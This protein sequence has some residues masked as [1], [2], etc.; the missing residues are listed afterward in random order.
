MEIRVTF[1]ADLEY[2]RENIADAKSI[3]VELEMGGESS[4]RHDGLTEINLDDQDAQKSHIEELVHN[5]VFANQ[6]Y[7]AV[8]ECLQNIPLEWTTDGIVES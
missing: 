5:R 6:K 7:H 8:E 1:G 3:E 2:S 4:E